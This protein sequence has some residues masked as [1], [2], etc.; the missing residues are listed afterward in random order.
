[1]TRLPAE[2]NWSLAGEVI[3]DSGNRLLFPL[4]SIPV[5]LLIGMTLGAAFHH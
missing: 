5:A 2:F 1:M 3:L 4:W